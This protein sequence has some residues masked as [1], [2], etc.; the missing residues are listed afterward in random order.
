[1]GWEW[2][3][4]VQDTTIHRQAIVLPAFETNPQLE[5]QEGEDAADLAINSEPSVPST[6]PV[7]ATLLFVGPVLATLAQKGLRCCVGHSLR[8][9]MYRTGAKPQLLKMFG[10]R[11]LIQFAEFYPAGHKQTNYKKWFNTVHPY[12]IRRVLAFSAP[13]GTRDLA[14]RA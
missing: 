5:I 3:A 13:S 8:L 9:L 11:S 10:E 2:Q 1:M 7:V 12:P 14:Y 6:S 4:L